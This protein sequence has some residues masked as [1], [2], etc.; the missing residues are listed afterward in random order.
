MKKRK[1]FIL[2]TRFYDTG[3]RILRVATGCRYTHASIGLQEDMNTF[4][5]FRLN[6]FIEEKVTRYVKPGKEASPCQLYELEVSKKV[7]NRVKKALLSFVNKKSFFAYSH[8][9]VVMGLMRIPLKRERKFFCSQF[10]AHILEKTNALT[11]KKNSSLYMP[12][13][14]TKL[15]GLKLNFQGNMQ[16]L[17]ANF[18]CKIQA[19]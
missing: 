4:Y 17:L 12:A 1:I 6:G 11:L 9:G 18:E 8:L 10:V 3:A 19:A 15:P 13:D 14:F 5:S 16:G 2:L 7:Y